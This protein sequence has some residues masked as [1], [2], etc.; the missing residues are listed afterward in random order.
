MI[1]LYSIIVFT[2]YLFLVDLGPGSFNMRGKSGRFLKLMRSFDYES[3][4]V[5][6]F[7]FWTRIES[8]IVSEA[9]IWP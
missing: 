8:D 2:S 5:A 9:R 4:K 1:L 6:H 7:Q 3:S